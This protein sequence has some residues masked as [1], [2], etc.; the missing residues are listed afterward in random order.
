M[1]YLY[2][3]IP[4]FNLNSIPVVTRKEKK[5]VFGEKNQLSID[6]FFEGLWPG[7]ISDA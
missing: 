6:N 5:A 3:K 2:S 1:Q 4:Y 7:E